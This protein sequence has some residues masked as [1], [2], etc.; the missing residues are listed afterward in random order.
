MRLK[1]LNSLAGGFSA[2]TAGLMTGG[3]DKSNVTA[4]GVSSQANSTLLPSTINN[5]TVGGA[6]TGV[7]LPADLAVGDEVLIY[8]NATGAAINVYPNVG[9]NINN[10]GA[11]TA[12][13]LA[14]NVLARVKCI[15]PNVY[16]M[17][18]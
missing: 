2:V 15:A 16:G 1:L 5:V 17:T 8:N 12:V 7:R 3:G 4:A 10:A 9:G 14:N 18:V 11:N 13:A 6:N